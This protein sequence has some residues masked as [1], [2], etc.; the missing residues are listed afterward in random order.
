MFKP[1]FKYT[2][3]IVID[4]MHIEKYKSIVE[5][6]VI[7]P[8]IA[9]NL[10]EESKLKSTHFSTRIEGNP[11]NIQQ[12]TE[13]ISRD[14]NNSRHRSEIEVRNYWDAL[15]FIDD[16]KL[17]GTKIDE[18]FI[19]KLHSI[20]ENKNPGRKPKESKYREPTQPGVLFA[21]YDNV[22]K[23]PDYIPPE[24]S[25]VPSLMKELVNWVN[26]TNSLPIPLKA[27]IVSYQL[28]T[29]H[30]FDDGN[31]RTSRA[32]SSYF[33]ALGNYD[34]KGFYSMEEF[35]ASDL[36]GYYK[37]IQ[38][39]LPVLY[40]EGRN[41]PVDLSPWLEYYIRI[42]KLAFEK[43]KL[44][45]SSTVQS[46]ISDLDLDYLN[47]KDKTLLYYL[48]DH[49]EKLIKPKE[50]A[51]LFGVTPRAVSKWCK[52][53]V[54]IGLLKVVSGDKRITSYK[55]GDKFNAKEKETFPRWSK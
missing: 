22:T 46:N 50:I 11:L 45:L 7:P 26:E 21:V 51:D 17:K 1:K 18:K 35:Y 38:M 27:G 31:G 12:V 33:L 42:M 29:I 37:N 39:G 19:K 2:D 24:A 5:S 28:L 49:P 25:D 54:N 53:W 6:S 55:L 13:V 4:L 3:N 41:D 10:R 36:Q 14:N 43:V 8:F 44:S 52:E 48:I 47:K 15:T 30:P 20:I 16:E 34:L 9:K 32:L 40:Y 23:Q